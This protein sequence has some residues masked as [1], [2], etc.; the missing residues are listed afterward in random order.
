M[1][2]ELAKGIVRQ[3][4][5]LNYLVVEDEETKIAKTVEYNI[6]YEMSKILRRFIDQKVVITLR[7]EVMR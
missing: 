2:L 3:G 7:V 1:E 6:N 4:N 5:K